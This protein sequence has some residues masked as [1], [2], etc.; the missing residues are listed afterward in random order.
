MCPKGC[1]GIGASVCSALGTRPR[2]SPC[3]QLAG[4]LTKE[5]VGSGG[6]K[7]SLQLMRMVYAQSDEGG[8]RVVVCFQV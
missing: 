7:K 8:V 2:Y 5:E 4:S 1:L 6:S 3:V